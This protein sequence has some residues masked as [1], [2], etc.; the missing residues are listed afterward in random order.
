MGKKILAKKYCADFMGAK[1]CAW[2]GK[3]GDV[4]KET[5]I[6]GLS[7]V[8]VSPQKAREGIVDQGSVDLARFSSIDSNVK[9]TEPDKLKSIKIKI[10]G[11]GDLLS[12]DGDRQSFRK[13]ILT[14]TRERLPLSSTFNNVPQKI[15]VFLKPAPFMQ[16]DNPEIKALAE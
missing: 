15:A 5:G 3:D 16:S 6:L 13:G 9:I 14:I 11:S 12:L 8:K 7:M 2:L 4:L 1:N 10:G